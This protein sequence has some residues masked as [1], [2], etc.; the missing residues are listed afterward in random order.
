M[1]NFLRQIR[2]HGFV[3]VS[4]KLKKIR[5]IGILN[6]TF[7]SELIVENFWISLLVGSGRNSQN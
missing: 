3:T 4:R 2:G 6:R 5:S 1:A 7:T